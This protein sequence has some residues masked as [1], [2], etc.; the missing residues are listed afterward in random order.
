MNVAVL[1]LGGG[2]Q[3]AESTPQHDISI[4][5][6]GDGV[7]EVKSTN[8]NTHLGGGDFDR[9]IINWMADSFQSDKGIDLR[10]DPMA[11]QRLKEAAEKA[12][13]ELSSSMETE[14]NLPYITVADG[15][16]Q[17]LVMK[18]TRAKFEQLCDDLIRATIEPCRQ[19]M[20]DAGL[21]NSDINEVILVGGSSR[22]PAV[23]KKVEELLTSFDSFSGVRSF[24]HFG[25][26]HSKG[27]N[28]DEVVA[29][30]AAIQGGVLTGEVKDVLLLDE[31][32][33]SELS[34]PKPRYRDPRR[35]DDPSD[36]GQPRKGNRTPL[37]RNQCSE[38]HHHPH[39]EPGLLDGCRLLW[40]ASLMS[41]P[42]RG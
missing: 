4:L 40:P 37:N 27:V 34:P 13:I 38:E 33:S 32:K 21:S 35:R 9:K 12:K 10:K 25:K 11:M 16:P 41:E 23:Q 3:S 19:A 42:A 22:I 36:R 5:N 2:T 8:G 15:V 6:L 26:V 31:R 14:I 28:P 20:H 7:F 1:D 24:R 29:I 18:L 39:Q 17:H 30:G